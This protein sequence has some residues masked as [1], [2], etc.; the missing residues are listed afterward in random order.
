LELES[1]TVDSF[2]SWYDGKGLIGNWQ[3]WNWQHFHIGN[4]HQLKHSNTQTLS[5]THEYADD[6]CTGWGYADELVRIIA[7]YK[8]KFVG[9][10]AK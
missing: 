6:V 8:L 4:I 1:G 9:K 5:R 2:S 10:K 7:I 3:H